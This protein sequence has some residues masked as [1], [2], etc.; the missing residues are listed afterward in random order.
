MQRVRG[1]ISGAVV[2]VSLGVFMILLLHAVV[3]AAALG[4]GVVALAIFAVVAT[5]SDAHETAADAAWRAAAPD[6]PPV[7]DRVTLERLQAHL[8]APAKRRNA[9]PRSGDDSRGAEPSGAASQGSD[10]T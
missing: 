2:G 6:L 3:W 8:P 7:S 1:L 9:S 5:R 10:P 4:G